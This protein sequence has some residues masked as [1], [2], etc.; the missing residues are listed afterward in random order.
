[1]VTGFSNDALES[2]KI[3]ECFGAKMEAGFRNEACDRT[4]VCQELTLSSSCAV[5]TAASTR[6]GLGSWAF[7]RPPLL[8]LDWGQGDGPC[9]AA[10][11]GTNLRDYKVLRRLLCG[12]G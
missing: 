12:F 4:K 5:A 6:C 7:A 8:G 2:K 9:K 3:F 1:M 10:T 11:T